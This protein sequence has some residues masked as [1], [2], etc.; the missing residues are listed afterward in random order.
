[1]A[2]GWR[3]RFQLQ[4]WIP[5]QLLPLFEPSALPARGDGPGGLRGSYP[6]RLFEANREGWAAALEGAAIGEQWTS[7]GQRGR[8]LL[9]TAS[10]LRGI[11]PPRFASTPSTVVRELGGFRLNRIGDE[12]RGEPLVLIASLINRWYI[13]DFLP[14]RSFLAALQALGRPLYLVEPL[15]PQDDDDRSLEELCSGPLRD[16]VDTVRAQHGVERVALAGYCLGGTLAAMLA[17]RYP[18]RVARLATLCAP[19]RFRDGGLFRTWLDAHYL[20]VELALR[21]RRRIPAWLVHLPFWWLRPTIKLNKLVRLARMRGERDELERFLA[22]EVWNH[23]NLDMARGVFRSWVGELYQRDALA[24]GQLV[25]DGQPVRLDTLQV[26]VLA[27]SAKHDAI[28]PPAS[29]E[30]L[31]ELCSSAPARHQRLEASHVSL[32]TSPKNI[33]RVC[34][35]LNRWLA[36]EGEQA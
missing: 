3:G 7:F 22:L 9:T 14:G 16:L 26:P 8:D 35:E 21:G 4:R 32:F 33:E 20:D 23:D 30:A 17:G 25:V 12:G 2:D 19:V 28:T 13:L 5:S 10:R 27:I 36:A 31:A 29:V 15:T 11:E 24:R 1:M 6:M 34:D 18:E